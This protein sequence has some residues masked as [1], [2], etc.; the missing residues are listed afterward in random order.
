L[1]VLALSGRRLLRSW[2]LSAIYV[3]GG[4]DEAIR[5]LSRAREDAM[6]DL[7]RSKIRLKAFLLRQDI[8]RGTRPI[9]AGSPGWYVPLPCSRSCFRSTC[10][11]SL[12]R[13]NGWSR[14][15]REA[16][17]TGRLYPVVA[18]I[19]AL[20]GVELT[21][22]IILVA[23]VGEPDAVRYAA[24]AVELSRPHAV[25]VLVRGPAAAGRHYQGRRTRGARWWK[26]RGRTVTTRA[27]PSG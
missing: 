15:L 14:R 25:G 2:D 13:S 7:K 21:A 9:C 17:K 20:R 26:G 11:P 16:V 23:E 22:A 8:R 3:P 19:Q 4:D 24:Q 10:G 5:D 6:H 18:A 1:N 27:S 12:S